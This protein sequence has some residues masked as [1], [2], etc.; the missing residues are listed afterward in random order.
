MPYFI[1]A[2]AIIPGALILILVPAALSMPAA[3]I[4]GRRLSRVSAKEA[5][6]V[7]LGVAVGM[8]V[9]HMLWFMVNF[10]RGNLAL[11]AA[12]ILVA[13]MGCVALPIIGC[14]IINR[15]NLARSHS[16]RSRR[17]RVAAKVLLGV[18][19]AFILVAAA[20]ILFRPF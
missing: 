17:N 20:M 2:G 6:A 11:L 1:P 9:I 16:E 12:G 15:C 4:S 7:G 10:G 14:Q 19:G 18:I 13:M 8:G 3:L 5:T